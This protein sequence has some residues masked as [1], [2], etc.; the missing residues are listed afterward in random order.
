MAAVYYALNGR[1]LT[2]S[3]PDPAITEPPE[4]Y[5][6][7]ILKRQNV[8]TYDICGY[9]SLPGQC[10]YSQYLLNKIVSANYKIKVWIAN[11]CYYSDVP[12]TCATSRSHIG[13]DGY[14]KTRCSTALTCTSI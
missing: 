5:N 7:D 3:P 1:G 4:A 6:R 9:Y 12:M 8:G 10:K 14:I 13:C 11:F 2:G